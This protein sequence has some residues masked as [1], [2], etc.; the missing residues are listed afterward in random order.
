M[1]RLDYP[2]E[3][4]HVLLLL[5]E[6]D[7]S[8]INKVKSISLPYFIKYLIVPEG[9][10]KTKPRACNYG[11][12]ELS[13]CDYITIF[14]AEDIPESDQL[15]KAIDHFSKSSEDVVCLQASL[16]YRNGKENLLSRMFYIEYETWFSFFISGLSESKLP[17]PLGGTSNH[18]KTNQL[19]E[20][21][22]WNPY[23][24]TEDA[25]LGLR[26]YKKGYKV[27]K[28]D[29]VTWEE[30]VLSIWP[31][32]KQRTRWMKGYIQT[33]IES[34][35]TGIPLIHQLSNLFFVFGTPFIAMWTLPLFILTILSFFIDLGWSYYEQQ[36][37]FVCLV[38]GN[39]SM[40]LISMFAVRK[41]PSYII[42]CLLL[43]FYWILH[44]IASWRAVYQYFTN[45]HLWE[46][47]EH[48]ISKFKGDI[49]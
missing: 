39:L 46:K 14:D 38:Y 3:N 16:R 22:G 11:L 7:Y 48:G 4:L 5:E 43:P 35:K 1:Y 21:G 28:L 31:W 29:S 26:I 8:T 23:N 30:S 6:D 17:I 37:A 41:E 15:K 45:K 36:L 19:I 10:P 33:F 20:L 2:K 49:K 12:K 18:F 47:T 9:F 40:I 44:S 32:I 13:F 34:D 27:E 42:F 25:E 24:V